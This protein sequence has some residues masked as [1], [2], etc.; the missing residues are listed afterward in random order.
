MDFKAFACRLDLQSAEDLFPITEIVT[1]FYSHHYCADDFSVALTFGKVVP[2]NFS[3][4]DLCSVQNFEAMCIV[5]LNFVGYVGTVNDSDVVSVAR[6]HKVDSLVK[7]QRLVHDNYMVN[8]LQIT[9]KI[10]KG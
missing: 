9:N 3:P 5:D 2:A 7:I 1:V 4:E 6:L 10:I 8:Q